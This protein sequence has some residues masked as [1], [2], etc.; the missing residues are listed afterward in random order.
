MNVKG[1]L[2]ERI[3]EDKMLL[4]T[5]VSCWIVVRF[6][7]IRHSAFSSLIVASLTRLNLEARPVEVH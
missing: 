4:R 2:I 1:L 3:D 5:V 6:F 7:G